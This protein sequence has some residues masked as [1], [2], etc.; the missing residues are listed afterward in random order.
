MYYLSEIRTVN[1]K[2][3][4][5]VYISIPKNGVVRFKGPNNEGKSIIIDALEAIISCSLNEPRVR[6]ALINYDVDECYIT[7][8]RNDGAMLHVVINREASKTF[9]RLHIPNTGNVITRYLADKGLRELVTLFGFH[10]DVKREMSLNLYITYS[11]LLFV[12][13]SESYNHD[14]L[15]SVITDPVAESAKEQIE[16]VKKQFD[17]ALK[18]IDVR[19]EQ[20]Q[21]TIANMK[22]YDETKLSERA[23]KLRHLA[24]TI[25]NLTTINI[26]TLKKSIDLSLIENLETKSLHKI[27][28]DFKPLSIPYYKDIELLKGIG[29]LSSI[30]GQLVDYVTKK[31]AYDNGVCFACGRRYK[32]VRKKNT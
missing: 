13:T 26:P 18:I 28:K 14:I 10:W 27:I 30:R 31:E 29:D 8:K 17:A 2:S 23:L 3:H 32:R 16:A 6:L 15:T 4:K 7:L 20:Q 12:T 1:I 11:P 24:R 5:D 19:I 9:Y 21:A 25:T 22:F